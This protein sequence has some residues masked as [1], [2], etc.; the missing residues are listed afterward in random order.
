MKRQRLIKYAFVLSAICILG[1]FSLIRASARTPDAPSSAPQAPQ[2]TLPT[3]F[4]YQGQLS[5]HGAPASG[6]YEFRFTLYNV[7]SGGS[8]LA[9]TTPL[10]HTVPVTQG[11]FTVQLDFGD[12]FENQQLF[13]EIAVRPSGSAQ[14]LTILTPRQSIT[15]V[16]HARYAIHAA[17]ATTA[18][19]VAWSGVSDKPA[20]LFKRSIYVPAGSMNYAPGADLSAAQNGIKW[21]GDTNQLGGFG[22]TQPDDWDKTT[23]FTVTLYFALHLTDSPGH[24]RWRLHAGTS[25]L[26]LP[27]DYSDSGWDQI[28]YSAEQDAALLEYGD[29]GGHF[30]LMK[31]QSWVS[32]WS[33]TYNDW[34]F[35][36]GVTTNNAFADDPMWYF[37]FER[38]SAVS[39][40]ETYTGDMYV[41]GAEITYQAVQ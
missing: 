21:P 15:P 17:E 16:P 3:A 20:D 37:Y 12:I 10:T 9:G 11:H 28:T 13:L 4:T 31:A 25:N 36:S 19:N 33:S 5:D 26:N 8:P 6:D 14:A 1:M 27:T 23:P 2:A 39:N 22:V 30:Y 35:G 40:G 7:E 29:A 41:V 32:K 34:Y 38:G 18:Q 24:V